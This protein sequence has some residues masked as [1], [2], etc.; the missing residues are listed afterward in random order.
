MQESQW[1]VAVLEILVSD[2]FFLLKPFLVMTM[3]DLLG[4]KLK[5][6]HWMVPVE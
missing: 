4:E 2:F 1:R 3:I 5:S 6:K